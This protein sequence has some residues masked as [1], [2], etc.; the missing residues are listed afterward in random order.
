MSTELDYPSSSPS[1]DFVPLVES[2]TPAKVSADGKPLPPALLGK[3]LRHVAAGAK[4]VDQEAVIALE[5]EVLRLRIRGTAFRVI[6][7]KLG[8]TQSYRL[9]KRALNRSPSEQL[10]RDALKLDGERLDSLQDGMW[11]KAMAGD[12]RAIE[13]MLKLLERRS[14]LYGYDFADVLGARHAEVEEAKVKLMAIA[15][16][17]ALDKAELTPEV[18]KFITS[19]FVTE[20]R[21][22]EEK[23]GED[24]A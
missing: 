18:R 15:L 20:L 24:A 23:T 22:I 13:V 16:T 6:E 11:E 9:Y 2:P 4:A 3:N 14:R 17:R 10:R 5:D 8:I 1:D 12:A 21:V 19:E 7:R